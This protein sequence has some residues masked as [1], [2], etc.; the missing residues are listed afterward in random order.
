[1]A[2]QVASHQSRES[3][4]AE[5]LYEAAQNVVPVLQAEIGT[6]TG[7]AVMKKVLTHAVEQPYASPALSATRTP[8]FL[9]NMRRVAVI[10]RLRMRRAW[11]CM[12][13]LSSRVSRMP[14]DY[15][16][17]ASAPVV[18]APLIKFVESRATLQ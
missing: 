9:F 12:G 5:T 17:M 4:S 13:Y 6:G 14:L 16:S 3:V 8:R 10:L 11:D 15:S 1:M 7:C 18:I 2:V